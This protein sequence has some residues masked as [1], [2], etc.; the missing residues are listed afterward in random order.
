MRISRYY[1]F[2][3]QRTAAGRYL[4]GLHRSEV[5]RDAGDALHPGRW[6][7]N[8]QLTTCTRRL[9]KIVSIRPNFPRQGLTLSYLGFK[10]H[11]ETIATHL[12]IRTCLLRFAASRSIGPPPC[13]SSLLLVPLSLQAAAQSA[14]RRA[15]HAWRRRR[16]ACSFRAASSG[17]A[18]HA[19]GPAV[20]AEHNT[21]QRQVLSAMQHY[22][23]RAGP[24]TAI[25]PL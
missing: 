12:L 25:D 11:P 20:H 9:V 22:P 21:Q 8:E 15:A 5:R 16:H 17:P 19:G 2:T 1:P 23:T 18:Q 10:Q 14:L 24:A 4:A 3:D 7:R 13:F 6:G